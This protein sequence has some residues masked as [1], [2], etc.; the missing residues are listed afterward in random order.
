MIISPTNIYDSTKFIDVM[1]SI[2][3]F[4]DDDMIK[5]IVS[6]Y[7]DKGYDAKYIKMYLRNHFIGCLHSIQK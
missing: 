2:S 5:E 4:V 7:A 3:D 1:E 6:V